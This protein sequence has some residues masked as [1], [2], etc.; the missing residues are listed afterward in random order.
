MPLKSNRPAS[1]ANAPIVS[2]TTNSASGTTPN[3]KPQSCII[4]KFIA[5]QPM[6]PSHFS[7]TQFM[8][9]TSSRS[10]IYQQGELQTNPAA[11]FAGEPGVALLKIVHEY[12]C[13]EL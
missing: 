4:F 1:L 10:L 7:S 6:M 3:E 9:Y 12:E 5:A 2:R 8:I 11:L 13:G